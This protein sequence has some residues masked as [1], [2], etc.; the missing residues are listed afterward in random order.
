MIYHESHINMSN[1]NFFRVGKIMVGFWVV[2][3]TIFMV[4]ASMG[5]IVSLP[6][7]SMDPENEIFKAQEKIDKEFPNSVHPIPF[8]V[9]SKDG[10]DILTK[11]V[12]SELFD[13]SESLRLSGLGKEYL[14]DFTIPFLGSTN[15]LG[16]FSLA[17]VTESFLKQNGSS[18]KEA[19]DKD[20]KKALNFLFSDPKYGSFLRAQLSSKA[21]FKNNEWVSPAFAFFVS[22][23][24]DK[25]GG[26]VFRRTVGGDSVMLNKEKF[27]RDIEKSLQGESYKLLGIG[28]DL[29]IEA[30][31]EGYSSS[32]MVLI[33][34]LL[35]TLAI[36]TGIL[37]R[38]LR[39]FILTI[40]GLITLFVWIRGF[41]FATLGWVKPSLTTDVILP[42]ASMA[43]GVDF[44][45]HIIHQ[46][47]EGLKKDN[48]NFR[49]SFIKSF[50]NVN[51]GLFLAM[52]TTAVAFGSNYVSSVEAVKAFAITGVFASFVAYFIMGIVIPILFILWEGKKSKVTSIKFN[53][54]NMGVFM[55]FVTRNKKF[56]V[57]I[58][59]VVTIFFGSGV[60]L[61]E[62]NL[63][64]KD[65]ISSKS[66][67]VVSLDER[68]IHFGE[69]RGEEASIY[70][71]GNFTDIK[72]KK[73]LE[74]FMV[75][76][77]KNIYLAHTSE[78][79]L[80][81]PYGFP[82]INK[83][84]EDMFSERII[85]EVVGAREQEVVQKAFKSLKLDLE[86]FDGIA[87]YEIVGS[88]FTRD[89]S[90]GAVTESL[91]NTI[92]VA[93]FVIFLILLI[94]F[95]SF[96]YS[97]VT[98]IPMLLVVVWVYGLMGT[99]GFSLNFITATIAAVSL[100]VGIDYSV[101]IVQRFRQEY[102]KDISLEN[103]LL[104]VGQTTGFAIFVSA[105]SS[106]IGFMFL[107][108]AQMPL[109][110]TYGLLVAIMIGFSFIASFT[111]LPI[112]LSLKKKKPQSI[113][114]QSKI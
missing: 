36:F 58:L 32:I 51:T 89:A 59:L 90:L 97:F 40:I 61:V 3:T 79:Q 24:N 108:R 60:F 52:L 49:D 14:V 88:P 69:T 83:I 46:Y 93:L 10:E 15:T 81:L 34:I 23:D 48:D 100:G 43:F 111:V 91:V 86:I 96:F 99:Y 102:R 92:L 54:I 66:N 68:D 80:V 27:N 26:G 35:L 2:L 64:P 29:N 75:L 56:V 98:I 70:I 45:F 77:N 106:G 13:K 76:L 50:K 67:F 12:L 30:E 65:F 5:Y 16:L 4:F 73:A 8:E 74:D 87:T 41:P 103:I 105:L 72:V 85:F 71:K 62:K 18:L 11:S 7:A 33:S 107:S 28:I 37:F 25:L 9:L 78:G 94:V 19:T 42:I 95:R 57:A 112:L 55:N 47:K 21:E 101:H 104:K 110:A 44:L 6:Q 22:A 113:S 84:N 109:F 53:F 63:D 82:K 20:V 39:L 114:S 31:E 1:K 17:D 38:S